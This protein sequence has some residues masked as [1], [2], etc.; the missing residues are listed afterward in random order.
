MRPDERKPIALAA[1]LAGGRGRRMGG[2]KV[3]IPL[4][5]KPLLERVWASLAEVAETVVVVGGEPRLDAYGVRTIP[6]LYPGAD[7]L[8]GLATGLTY[9]RE[10]L[11][12]DAWMLGVA[13]DMPFLEPRLLARLAQAC[14]DNDIVVPRTAAGHEPLCSLYRATCLPAMVR[15]IERGNLRIRNLY[16]QV[17]MTE[18][19]EEEIRKLDPELRSF[20]NINRPE[21]LVTATRLLRGEA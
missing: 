19:G 4:D 12:P 11:G 7:S 6:D 18:V 3:L 14:G 21:D 15:E 9:V 17:R 2:D 8:G 13:C 1:I 16:D 20:L 5:G 10:T